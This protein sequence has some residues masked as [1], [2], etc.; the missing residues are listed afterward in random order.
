MRRSCQF[1]KICLEQVGRWR[2]LSSFGLILESLCSLDSKMS[3]A[4]SCSFLNLF[5]QA[6]ILYQC[7]VAGMPAGLSARDTLHNESSEDE[8]H[9]NGAF[10]W[11]TLLF[12]DEQLAKIPLPAV[13]QKCPLPRA[14]DGNYRQLV[15]QRNLVLALASHRAKQ[16]E[17]VAERTRLLARDSSSF[18]LESSATSSPTHSRSSL[19]PSV[20]WAVR[21]M[22]PLL[23]SAARADPL[24]RTHLKAQ[25]IHALGDII[26]PLPLHSLR[27]EPEE[28]M[29]ALR[30]LV[31]GTL[32]Q[33]VGSRAS[34]SSAAFSSSGGTA[35]VLG[36]LPAISPVPTTDSEGGAKL[37]TTPLLT[38]TPSKPSAKQKQ[39]PISPLSLS[40]SSDPRSPPLFLSFEQGADKL[41][42]V[43]VALSLHRGTLCPV[44]D[45]ALTLLQTVRR[46]PSSQLQM[47]IRPCLRELDGNI[48]Q[49]GGTYGGLLEQAVHSSFTHECESPQQAPTAA[50]GKQQLC[51]QSRIVLSRCSFLLS[52]FLLCL[53]LAFFSSRLFSFLFTSENL[54]DYS[55]T[56]CDGTFLFLHHSGGLLK[57]GTGFNDTIR[58]HIYGSNSHFAP[59]QRLSLA[60]LKGHLFYRARSF[61][62][63]LVREID[64]VTLQDVDV[65]WE[66]QY[67]DS[68][69]EWR[70][71][72]QQHAAETA[73]R[74]RTP[75]V[76][77]STSASPAPAPA[78]P[79]ASSVSAAAAPAAVSSSS[80]GSLSF[81]SPICASSPAPS[82]P[83]PVVTRCEAPSLAAI[84]PAFVTPPP[85]L[86]AASPAAAPVSIPTPYSVLSTPSSPFTP[87]TPAVPT[88]LSVSTAQAPRLSTMPFLWHLG[89]ESIS[90]PNCSQVFSDGEFLYALSLPLHSDLSLLAAQDVC[91]YTVTGNDFQMQVCS[92]LPQLSLSLSLFSPFFSSWSLCSYHSYLILLSLFLFF[93]H[94]GRLTRGSDARVQTDLVQLSD[95]QSQV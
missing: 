67:R 84:N 60:F 61:A 2:K 11:D 10:D 34:P 79:H 58:G 31:E 55:A 83:P 65:E 75:S 49:L 24:G 56:A 53:L 89:L 39:A 76:L 27:F 29:N 40:P 21:A 57:I 44:L 13:S 93:L 6:S 72:Q 38:R 23:E 69:K 33:W 71:R 15:A 87:L 74:S 30:D 16:M 92:A 95:V 91:T 20:Q 35:G 42:S 62:R 18:P 59:D 54:R 52:V 46:E 86:A 32:Q 81:S 85:T 41:S 19:P 9:N 88:P 78:R 17:S 7:A 50:F 51:V 73:D 70:K 43:L 80:A 47:D 94:V 14:L 1:I 82:T 26:T 8:L 63:Q 28:T 36:L 77:S 5:N 90:L 4:E 37:T 68:A 66:K 25:V 48:E 64:T 22:F 12:S 45:T 3:N